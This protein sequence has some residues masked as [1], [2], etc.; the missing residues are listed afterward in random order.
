MISHKL[1]LTGRQQQKI[2]QYSKSWVFKLSLV[3]FTAT[4]HLQT[5]G[6]IWTNLLIFACKLQS[7]KYKRKFFL[8]HLDENWLRTCWIIFS[9]CWFLAPNHVGFFKDSFLTT[10][11]LVH[12]TFVSILRT[13]EAFQH[14]LTP[15]TIS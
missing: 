14:N 1:N 10:S 12:P 7:K 15:V 3:F 11:L 6:L 2:Y 8:I 9:T 4:V 13:I 5:I